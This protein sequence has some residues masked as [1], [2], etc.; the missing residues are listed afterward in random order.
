[1]DYPNKVLSFSSV[2]ISLIQSILHLIHIPNQAC[3]VT[4]FRTGERHHF[5]VTGAAGYTSKI[6]IVLS[7]SVR[8]SLYYSNYSFLQTERQC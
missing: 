5:N 8:S 7:S 3:I 4:V 2:Q 6:V 1:M